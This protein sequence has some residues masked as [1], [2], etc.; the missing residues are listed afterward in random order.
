V[1][2]RGS[3]LLGCALLLGGCEEPDLP[4]SWRVTY[5]RVLGVR[6][7]VAGDEERATPEP[8][9]RVRVRVLIVGDEPI[10]SLSYDLIACPAA[11]PRGEL[12]SCA[13]ETFFAEREEV[14]ELEG[15]AGLSREL[16][17]ELEVP[18]EAE[19]DGAE[20]VLIGGTICAGGM[21]ESAEGGEGRCEGS[22]ARPVTF[23]AHVVLALHDADVNHNPVLASD[24]IRFDDAVWPPY[25]ISSLPSDEDAGAADED[26]GADDDASDGGVSPTVAADG[27]EHV[28][29][30]S[31][32]AS[33]RET[34]DGVREEL[35]L[36][37]FVTAGKLGRRF[38]VLEREQD[39]S[40]PFEVKWHIPR[41]DDPP[42][43]VLVIFVLRDQRGG[44][45]YALRALEVE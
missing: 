25:A 44:V 19:L 4:K 8:G 12:P 13:G 3:W 10:E 16:V 15:A 45:D 5:A 31:L 40:E 17:V 22:S 21:A 27:K 32:E 29:E 38:S 33:E 9:E 28:I 6:A 23:T 39:G 1:S 11:P 34:R 42:S 2:T 7:E 35:Q 24:A 20:R 41:L 18:D 37:H 26:A 43:E 36:S 30:I 14:T